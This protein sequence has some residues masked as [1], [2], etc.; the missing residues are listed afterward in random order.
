[1]DGVP[2]SS[3]ADFPIKSFFAIFTANLSPV[4]SGVMS[5]FISCPY[6]GIAAS[7]RSVSL[8][9]SPQGISPSS[10]PASNSVFHISSAFSLARYSSTPSSPVYP[11]LEMIH[12]IP[13][14]SVSNTAWQYF[15]G[16]FSSAV[17]FLRI[18]IAFGP[19]SAS[20]A[21]PEDT[22]LN[23]TSPNWWRN[24]H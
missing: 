6:N 23:V 19:C 10:F 11:V 14:T 1:M 7:I 15:F 9:P 20:C 2:F 3:K 13:A 21:Y 18:C 8:A 4:S 12:G 22:S 24:I 17:S 16:I 5:S